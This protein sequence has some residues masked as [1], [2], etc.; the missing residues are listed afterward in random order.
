MRNERLPFVAFVI[1]GLCLT[2][3]VIANIMAPS[4][5]PAPLNAGTMKEVR[6][7][8]VYER[9]LNKC[10]DLKNETAGQCRLNAEEAAK[11]VQ[12]WDG[13]KWEPVTKKLNN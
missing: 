7:T 13:S 8:A 9:V 5:P 12:Y 10:M 2:S 4:E 1:G 3:I 11:A 6:D